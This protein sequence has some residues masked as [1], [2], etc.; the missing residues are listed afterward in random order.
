MLKEHQRAR[1][2]EKIQEARKRSA[3]ASDR[4]GV[5]SEETRFASI[6]ACSESHTDR[7]LRPSLKANRAGTRGFRAPEVLF[8]C[9]DQTVG[10][11]C[12]S[13]ACKLDS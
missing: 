5:P 11:G 7:V 4:V 2:A 13:Q 9:P 1:V 12:K 3:V 8:K 6:A 10:E